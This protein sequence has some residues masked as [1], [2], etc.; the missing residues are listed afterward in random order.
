MN[1]VHLPLFQERLLSIIS[2]S[3]YVQKLLTKHFVKLAHKKVVIR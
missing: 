1:F 3:I 2:E